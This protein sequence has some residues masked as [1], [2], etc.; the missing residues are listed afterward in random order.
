MGRYQNLID[1]YD[2]E[3]KRYEE[4]KDA[5]NYAIQSIYTGLLRY[6]DE[7]FNIILKGTKLYRNEDGSFFREFNLLGISKT[8]LTCMITLKYKEHTIYS[9]TIGTKFGISKPHDFEFKKDVD[10]IINQN[11]YLYEFLYKNLLVSIPEHIKDL[12]ET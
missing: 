2:K 12:V 10:H 9:A 6:F 3:S 1:L 5:C 4:N 7:D 11:N 8:P